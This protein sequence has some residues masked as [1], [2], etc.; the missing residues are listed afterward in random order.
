V[1][2]Q[3]MQIVAWATRT[4]KTRRPNKFLGLTRRASAELAGPTAA[5]DPTL[6]WHLDESDI[7][8]SLSRLYSRMHRHGGRVHG[9]VPGR[10]TEHGG[11]RSIMAYPHRAGDAVPIQIYAL[12][13]PNMPK[14]T[15]LASQRSEIGRNNR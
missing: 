12:P 3:R 1:L 8:S 10:T 14:G 2:A 7:H 13:L 4:A 9:K 15:I 5:L 6:V 11:E